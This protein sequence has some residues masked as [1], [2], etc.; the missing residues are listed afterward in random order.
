MT[1]A[2]FRFVPQYFVNTF[3]ANLLTFLWILSRLIFN[4]N[5]NQS[6]LSSQQCFAVSDPSLPDNPIVYVSGGF[7]KLTGYKMDDVSVYFICLSKS[8]CASSDI[9]ITSS[10]QVLGRNCRFLQGP[11]TDARAVDVIRRGV[12]AGRD[13]SVI[14]NYTTKNVVSFL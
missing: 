1:S 2:W 10:L 14:N 11:G 4:G 13:T 3:F 5:L 12:A 9:D 7:L 8:F 6:L